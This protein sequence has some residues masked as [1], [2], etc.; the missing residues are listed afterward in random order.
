MKSLFATAL[1]LMVAA[2]A[3][4]RSPIYK[5]PAEVSAQRISADEMQIALFGEGARQVYE[6]LAVEPRFEFGFVQ[7]SIKETK[8]M[9]CTESYLGDIPGQMAGPKYNCKITQSLR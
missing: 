4:A 5:A 1:V 2:P 6:N 9:T 3:F 8:T 7:Q